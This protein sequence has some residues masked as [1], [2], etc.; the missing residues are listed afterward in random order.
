MFSVAAREKHVGA[1]KLILRVFDERGLDLCEVD[2]AL[3]QAQE[4]AEKH[5]LKDERPDIA[6]VLHRFYWRRRY[7]VSS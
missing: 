3:K 6:K 1:V 7:P 5:A 4:H 2:R